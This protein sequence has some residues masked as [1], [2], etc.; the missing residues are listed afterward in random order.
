M[1]G[2]VPLLFS[3]S[4]WV[5]APISTSQWAP[6]TWSNSPIRLTASSQPRNPRYSTLVSGMASAVRGGMLLSVAKRLQQR[7]MRAFSDAC[8]ELY[9]IVP[10][11]PLVRAGRNSSGLLAE[12]GLEAGGRHRQAI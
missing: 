11:C 9:R 2:A 4:I 6:L 5:M 7:E 8:V 1:A 3:V 12:Q 10:L